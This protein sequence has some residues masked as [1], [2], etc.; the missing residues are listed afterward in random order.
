[1][2]PSISPQ[3]CPL[4]SWVVQAGF[5]SFADTG[6]DIPLDLTALV[7][8]N[9]IAT[10]FIRVAGD[11]MSGAGMRTGDLLVVDRSITPRDGHIVIAVLDGAFTVKRLALTQGQASLVAEHQDYPPIHIDADTDFQVWGVVTTCIHTYC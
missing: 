8:R 2:L 6:T 9:P 3:T 11:S 10:Y 7:V 5:P 4:V 1:M